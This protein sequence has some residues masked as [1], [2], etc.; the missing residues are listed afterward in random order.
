MKSVQTLPVSIDPANLKHTIKF[1]HRGLILTFA[2]T[3]T[4]TARTNQYKFR[5]NGTSK[6]RATYTAPPSK[7]AESAFQISC[8]LLFFYLGRFLKKLADDQR[9]SMTK[10]SIYYMNHM[11]IHPFI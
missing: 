3:P 5:P 10:G 7:N 2:S 1:Y 6:E 11:Y 4:Q 8:K 9:P